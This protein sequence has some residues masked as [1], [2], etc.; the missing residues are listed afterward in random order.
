MLISVKL[1][2][3]YVVIIYASR[4][5]N[6]GVW[7]KALRWF[8]MYL[9]KV[10]RLDLGLTRQVRK[11]SLSLWAIEIVIHSSF[12]FSF[13]RNRS[14]WTDTLILVNPHPILQLKSH[15]S[16]SN[17]WL[18][19]VIVY[20]A[21]AS[22]YRHKGPTIWLWWGVCVIWFAFFFP[23]NLW[24]QNFLFPDIQSHW[25]S[26]ISLQDFFLPRNQSAGYFFLKSPILAPKSQMVRP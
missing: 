4:H 17:P 2:A 26:G 1:L 3:K 8:F 16:K 12:H 25:M 19:K 20:R 15:Y 7:I 21:R 24:W 6:F 18:L 22:F 5:E 10:R 9:W 11:S 14:Y 23:S 13:Y